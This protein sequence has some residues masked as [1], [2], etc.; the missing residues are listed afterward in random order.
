MVVQVTEG[1][2][3]W[4]EGV[5]EECIIVGVNGEKFISHAHTVATLKHGRRPVSVRF[6][7]PEDGEEEEEEEEVN[8]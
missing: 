3:A 8:V 6:R 2:W 4:R 7:F 5:E 1:G